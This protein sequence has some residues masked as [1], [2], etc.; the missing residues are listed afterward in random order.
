MCEI[1]II[2]PDSHPEEIIVNAA[3]ELYESMQSSLGIMAVWAGGDEFTYQQYKSTEPDWEAVNNF[4]G[5]RMDCYRFFIHGRLATHGEV[6]VENAHPLAIDCDE[7]DVEY[8]MHNGIVGRR[9]NEKELLEQDG[10]DFATGVDSELIAHDFGEVPSDVDDAVDENNFARE[11]AFV[12]FGTENIL[13]YTN[14]RYHLTKKA[15]M[16]T[17]YRQ[18]GPERTD[19]RYNYVLT[20]PNGGS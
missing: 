19:D 12:L 16:S 8:L 15:E 18:Y 3:R 11:P 7:C 9:Q 4:V 5:E 1:A 20:K 2:N 10:H 6:T 13:I 17:R 14:A